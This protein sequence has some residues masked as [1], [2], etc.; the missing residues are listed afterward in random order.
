MTPRCERGDRRGAG[1]MTLDTLP[2]T[3]NGWRFD[4]L[5]AG[6]ADADLVL[7]LHG[8]RRRRT[9]GGACCPR[10]RARATASWRRTSAV[11]RRALGL[12]SARPTRPR[13]LV[14]DVLGIADA[15]GAR[16]FHLVGH[17][18][19][20]VLAWQV[21]ARHPERLRSLS[22]ASCPHP[23]A[24]RRALDDPLDRPGA[25][26]RPT[27][28]SSAPRAPARTCGSGAGSTGCANP[29]AAAGV[30]AEEAVLC[31]AAFS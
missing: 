12:R 29:D 15:L 10:S 8:S 14:A 18:W 13:P 25:A 24:F 28:R 1:G 22:V 6:R 17:D 27:W 30:S 4:A 20:G 19:G 26:L 2:I 3:A 31:V 7:L 9:R 21:A 5:A 16:R 23:L 11:S